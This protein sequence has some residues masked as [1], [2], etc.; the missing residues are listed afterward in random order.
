[1]RIRWRNLELPNRIDKVDDPQDKNH[2]TFNIEPFERGF[3]HTVGNSL[4]RILLS[5]IEGASIVSV[6]IRG[7]AHEASSV[8]GV[9]EDVTDVIL[10]LKKVLIV[11]SESETSATIS[12]SKNKKGVVKASDFECPAGVNV[13]NPDH[14]IC[15]M[16]DDV[17]FEVTCEVRKGRGY[18]VSEE[19]EL[20]E[21]EIG[22]I[23]ID[24][25][26]SP[27]QRVRYKIESTRVGKL[28]N[29]DRLVLDVWTDGTVDPEN[30]LVESAKILRKHIN[31]FVNYFSLGTEIQADLPPVEETKSDENKELDDLIAKFDV[32]IS[33]LELSVRACHCLEG[34]KISNVGELVARPESELLK[35]RNFGRTT[36][37]EVKKRVQTL[38][39]AFG[40][41]VE[42]L[43]SKRKSPETSPGIIN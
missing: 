15:T 25:L 36:L 22:R 18:V 27:V 43:R 31:P 21:Q 24:S 17:V 1:M 5:S 34:E 20:A 28:V 26:Y 11:M 35:I 7:V 39:L 41:D 12:I 32:P 3:G 14:V 6:K 19:N 10:N 29:Y 9:V 8:T 16:T 40:M 37:K 13:G 30:A 2:Q 33:D 4:R 23:A 38:G 42:N